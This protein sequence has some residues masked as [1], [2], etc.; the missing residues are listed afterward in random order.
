MLAGVSIF[1]ILLLVVSLSM[2]LY[3]VR[4]IIRPAQLGPLANVIVWAVL[5]AA[6][7]TT[8]A[9][10][11]LRRFHFQ[12]LWVDTAIWT[13]Y[14]ILGFILFVFTLCLVRDVGLLIL[15]VI[16]R[17]RARVRPHSRPLLPALAWAGKLARA[18]NVVVI[19][20]ALGLCLLGLYEARRVPPIKTVHV[21]LDA[22]DPALDGFRLVQLSDL[23]V[24]PTI[25]GSWVNKVVERTNTARP[26][27]VAITGDLV[28]SSVHRL[29]PEVRIL[30]HLKATHG[31]F[32]VTGN[33]EYYSGATPWITA[34]KEMGL[35]V[36]M[37]EHRIITHNGAEL[38]VAGVPDLRGGRFDPSHE[39]DPGRAVADAPD[40]LVRILFAH[41]PVMADQVQ[42]YGYDLMIAGHTHGG[43]FFPG[44]LLVHLFQPYVAGLH[45]IGEMLLYVSRGT[46][47]WGPP[48]RIGAPS[49]ITLL[50]LH[51][52]QNAG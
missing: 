43:Q 36:L 17:V 15:I 12:G 38:V 32:F 18:T 34:L 40:G 11:A 39:P 26:D 49:E 3:I 6:L 1:F 28:D 47:Y 7:L 8:P 5:L 37:N 33:H 14:L 24:G 27:L 25:R 22:L 16:D 41:Q 35:D 46:G 21:T 4:R 50:I 42:Q 31:V 2:G 52:S 9:V 30:Q 45:T 20:F 10:I 23:H 19:V 51:S 48:L 44:T 13:G 29:L